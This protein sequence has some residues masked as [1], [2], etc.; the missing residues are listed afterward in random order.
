M[1][2]LVG[3]VGGQAYLW[4]IYSEAVRSG[5]RIQG[6]IGYN[7]YEEVV[8]ALRPSF[9]QG[10]KSILIAAPDER[11]YRRFM[12]HIRKHQSWLRG[13]WRW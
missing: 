3:L 7:F 2:I 11:D 9:K 10:I 5:E 4:N 12:D 6:D 1:A 13:G 8:D